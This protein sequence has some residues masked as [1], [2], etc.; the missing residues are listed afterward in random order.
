VRDNRRLFRNAGQ[1]LWPSIKK[2]VIAWF[3]KE[4]DGGGGEEACK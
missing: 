1:I 3:R 4:G 2:M